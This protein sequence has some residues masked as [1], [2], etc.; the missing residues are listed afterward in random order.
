MVLQLQLS[1]TKKK[2]AAPDEAA[3]IKYPTHAIIRNRV[4]QKDT[5]AAFSYF[6]KK[7]MNIL[8]DWFIQAIRK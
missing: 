4:V 3:P 6:V 5:S 8:P 7:N 1:A 2:R